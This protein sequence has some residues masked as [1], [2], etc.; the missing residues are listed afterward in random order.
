MGPN[1]KKKLPFFV[2]I[3]FPAIIYYSLQHHDGLTK[4]ERNGDYFSLMTPFLL[5]S[6]EF[7]WGNGRPKAYISNSVFNVSIDLCLA[8]DLIR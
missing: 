5:P 3:I 7:I 1:G 8:I 4:Q 2:S 6:T